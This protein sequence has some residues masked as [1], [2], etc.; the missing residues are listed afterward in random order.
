MIRQL[1][2]FFV[3]SFLVVT[4]AISTQADM[5]SDFPQLQTQKMVTRAIPSVHITNPTNGKV[6]FYLETSKTVRTRH[7]LDSETS[8]TFTGVK[9]DKWFNVEVRS[10]GSKM[11]YGIDTGTRHHFQWNGKKLELYK[12]LPR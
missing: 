5:F 2:L 1:L 11:V 10:D 12:S 8:A 3:V 7:S 6:V 9:G 4:P